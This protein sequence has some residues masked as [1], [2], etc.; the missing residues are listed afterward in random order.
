[1]YKWVKRQLD[2]LPSSPGLIQPG[3]WYVHYDDGEK[4]QKMTYDVCRDY[5]KIFGGTVHHVEGN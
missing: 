2:K 3:N 1:M 4:S 5:A